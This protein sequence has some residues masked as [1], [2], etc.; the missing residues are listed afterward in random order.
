MDNRIS[1]RSIPVKRLPSGAVASVDVFE[2]EGPEPGPRAHVQSGIHGAETQGVPVALGLLRELAG[3]PLR[4]SMTLV[5]MANP[6]GIDRKA[7]A[8]TFGRF[9]PVTG[10]NWNRGYV[11]LGALDPDGA[12]LDEFVERHG[13]SPAE[14]VRRAFKEG[15]VDRLDRF[16]RGRAARGLA[17]PEDLALALPLQRL[18]ARADV[19]LDLHTGPVSA[20]YLYAFEGREEEARLLGFPHVIVIPRAFAGAM[21]EAS[22]VPWSDLEEAFG[23]RGRRLD[24][25]F[26]SFTLELGSEERADSREA[27]DDAARILGYLAHRGMLDFEAPPP[28]PRPRS[29]RL[30]DF[31]SYFAP[32]AGVAEYL[33]G[34][35]DAFAKGDALAVVHRPRMVGSLEH[36]EDSA[37]RVEAPEDGVVISRFPSSGVGTGTELFRVMTNVE[38]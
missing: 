28:P 35:G 11:D 20:R 9:C 10:A 38:G 8:Y 5:P 22:F 31:R 6:A 21:D 2:V 36:V 24:L 18:A 13:D 33:K 26:S 34:P 30:E 7:G 4:G 19:V 14:E 3:R 29:C 12:A 17:L 25:G 23:R 37:F 32:A 15:L 27:G 16:G 1:R